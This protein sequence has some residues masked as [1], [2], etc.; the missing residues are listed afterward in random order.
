ML[1]SFHSPPQRGVINALARQTLYATMTIRQGTQT[2]EIDQRLSEALALATRLRVPLFMT[3]LLFETAATLDLTGPASSSSLQEIEARAKE[4]QNLGR[5]QRLQFEED[6][7]GN[8]A[9]L[10]HKEPEKF[11]NRLWA[12]LLECLTGKRDDVSSAA[13]RTLDLAAAFPAREVTWDD[14]PMTAIR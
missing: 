10:M 3:R 5:E 12:F 1:E 6:V 13:L 7:R 9:V 2:R 14:Q 11:S 4:M 8:M